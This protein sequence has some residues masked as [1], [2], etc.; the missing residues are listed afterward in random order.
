MLIGENIKIDSI[1]H[2]I[3]H[4]KAHCKLMLEY[5]THIKKLFDF[6]T[7][8][9]NPKNVLNEHGKM[10]YGSTHAWYCCGGH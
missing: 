2:I 7:F 6:L 1:Y 10:G 8:Q 5:K 9:E 4:I 3:P